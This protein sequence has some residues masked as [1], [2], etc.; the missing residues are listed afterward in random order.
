MRIA[1]AVVALCG[2]LAACGRPGGQAPPTEVLA[3][4]VS[5][6]PEGPGD[7][8]WDRAPVFTAAL[9]PQ[10][11]VEP[12]KMKP[13]VPG[14]RVQAL[15]DGLS[16]AFRMRWKDRGAD[17]ER[18]PGAFSDACA[19]QLPAVLSPGLPSPM[20]GEKGREVEIACWSAAGQAAAEGKTGDIAHLYPNARLDHYPFTAAPTPK[21]PAAQARMARAYA[22]AEAAGNPWSTGRAVQDLVAQGPGTLRGAPATLSSGSGAWGPEGWTVSISRPLPKGLVAGSR[23]SA[24]FA[25]WDGSE[26]DAGSRKMWVPWT[27]LVLGAEEPG[28][29]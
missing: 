10:D 25:I 1:S 15:T 18:R 2:L 6:L 11:V 17:A 26:E 12:R 8:A 28:A 23:A 29:K 22:P 3:A 7:P 13:G 24:A 14:L 27:P 4:R 9:Q 19:V 21:E 5:R 20:M 16:I